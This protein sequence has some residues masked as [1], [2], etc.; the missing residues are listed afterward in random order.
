VQ[1]IIALDYGLKK[2]G[3]A[4]GQMVTRTARPLEVVPCYADKPNWEALDLI[5]K[6]WRPDLIV[7]GL[8]LHMDA[9]ETELSH[10]ATE[11][12]QA[13]ESRYGMPVTLVDERLSTQE[14]KVQAIEAGLKPGEPVDA[15]AAKLILETWIYAQR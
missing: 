8:P 5:I 14:A 11:F 15:F 3:V 2:I 13:V 4:V 12:S 1:K 9:T 10:L 6:T 7:V